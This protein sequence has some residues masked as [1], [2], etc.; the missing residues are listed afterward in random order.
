MIRAVDEFFNLHDFA[1]YVKVGGVDYVAIF[2][3]E[4]IISD[5]NDVVTSKPQLIMKAD[6]V[7]EFAYNDEIIVRDTVYYI[8]QIM[9]DGYGF[10]TII[11][12]KDM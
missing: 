12:S 4:S 2:D 3:D 10:A 7:E 6:D 9:P 1:E 11:I 8:K 5:N